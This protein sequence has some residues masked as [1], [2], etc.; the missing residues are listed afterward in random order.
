MVEN[1]LISVVL[2]TNSTE[3]YEDTLEAI[4]SIEQ[5]THS[6][7]EI[8]LVIDTNQALFEKF[9]QTKLPSR[10]SDANVILSNKSGLSNARNIGISQANGDYIAFIDDDAIADSFWIENLLSVFTSLEIGAVGGPIYPLWLGKPAKWIPPE[11]YWTMGCSFSFDKKQS[12]MHET[13]NLFGSNMAFRSSIFEEVGEFSTSFGLNGLSTKTG[14]ETEFLTRLMQQDSENKIFFN[15]AAIVFHRIYKF[16]KSPIFISK[17]SYHYGYA[18]AR[19]S[20]VNFK[21]KKSIKTHEKEFLQNLIKNTF[22]CRKFCKYYQFSIFYF[23]IQRIFI[24]FFLIMI[25]LGYI[26]GRIK[27]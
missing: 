10:L 16:R 25:F 3:R 26:Y 11:F 12:A 19:I 5:Q 18:T 4:K 13:T 9:K 23:I 22:S 24:L 7:I 8:I 6:Q 2:C 17:R 21:Q 15:P 20:K 1:S 27:R 14:E